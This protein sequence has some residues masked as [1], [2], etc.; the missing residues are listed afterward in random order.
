MS[1]WSASSVSIT[2]NTKIVTV[3]TG[4]DISTVSVGSGLIIG[5]NAPVEI[6]RAYIDN[7]VKK[8]ELKNNWTTGTVTAQAA[9][10]FPTDADLNA[11]AVALS[12]YLSTFAI[13]TKHKL[14]Q[15]QIIPHL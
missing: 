13:A 14:K 15:V 8:L 12:N 6:V 10:A 2:N 7:S 1:W 11:I 9:V 3:T 5:S 4:D